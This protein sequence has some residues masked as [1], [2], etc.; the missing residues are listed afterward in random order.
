VPKALLSRA[1]PAAAA[2][3]RRKIRPTAL[4][5]LHAIARCD[6]AA[7]A[8]LTATASLTPARKAPGARGGVRP[9]HPVS[10]GQ[11]RA[12]L[13]ANVATTLTIKLSAASLANLRSTVARHERVSVRL[14]LAATN[15]N[16]PA[17]ATA[18]VASL[19]LG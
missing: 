2:S 14:T 11:V 3:K 13:S 8:V 12:N 4:S 1:R 16:G 9:P 19:K 18:S 17:G 6:Q 7:T 15:S 10:L 5:R